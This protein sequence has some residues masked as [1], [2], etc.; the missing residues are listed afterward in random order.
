MTCCDCTDDCRDKTKCSCQQLTIQQTS[1]DR[2]QQID[3]EVGYVHRRLPE[4]VLTGVYECNSRCKCAKTCMNRVVQ[5]PM[6]CRLQVTIVIC[7]QNQKQCNFRFSKLRKEDGGSG[8]CMIFLK[9]L[10]FVFM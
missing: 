7:N 2:D 6:R 8:P 1:A 4:I 3:G 10:S 5:N 9:G